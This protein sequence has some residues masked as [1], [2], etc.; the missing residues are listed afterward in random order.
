MEATETEINIKIILP[1]D[2]VVVIVAV[3]PLEVVIHL[4][5]ELAILNVKI[6]SVRISVF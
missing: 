4:F 2:L 6:P 1:L 3:I 5:E